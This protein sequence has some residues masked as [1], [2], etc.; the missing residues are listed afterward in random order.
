VP[1]RPRQSAGPRRGADD[2]RIDRAKDFENLGETLAAFVTI[3]S[4]QLALSRL[5][6]RSS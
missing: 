5:A 2:A 1:A 4:T 3:F 6:R